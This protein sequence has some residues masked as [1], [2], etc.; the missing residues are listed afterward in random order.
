MFE[1]WA[2]LTQDSSRSSFVRR[3]SPGA[4]FYLNHGQDLSGGASVTSHHR[5]LPS[6]GQKTDFHYS[7]HGALLISEGRARLYPLV[8]SDSDDDDD[9]DA[10][11][12]VMINRLDV[13]SVWFMEKRHSDCVDSRCQPR[14]FYERLSC[15]S[16]AR[17][18]NVTLSKVNSLPRLCR[19]M[20]LAIVRE[21]EFAVF[22][23]WS[24]LN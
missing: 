15:E 10:S 11:T 4:S 13:P 14:F 8:S 1:S 23:N 16:V 9:D 24:D 2:S 3:I 20:L 7:I 18:T 17:N 6:R 12:R 5:C 21:S 22:R 19:L